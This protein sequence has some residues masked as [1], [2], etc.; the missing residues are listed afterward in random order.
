VVIRQGEAVKLKIGGSLDPSQ[1]APDWVPV[2]M[3]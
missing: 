3:E 2:A 1:L